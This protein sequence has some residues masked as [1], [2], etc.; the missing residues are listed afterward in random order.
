M[1]QTLRR[2]A[3]TIRPIL[4]A[5]FAVFVSLCFFTSVARADNSPARRKTAK[6]QFERAEKE[7]QA[8]EARSEKDR[9]LKEY[10]SVLNAYRR[11]YPPH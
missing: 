6:N 5:F 10:T 1:R 9:S 8:L 7:Y 11:V 4:R 2:D 3:A